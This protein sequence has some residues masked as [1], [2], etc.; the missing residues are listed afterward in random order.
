MLLQRLRE[1]L[2]DRSEP[3]AADALL[4]QAVYAKLK[5]EGVGPKDATPRHVRAALRAVLSELAQTPK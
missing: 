1:R 4:Q 2:D 3:D 5:I